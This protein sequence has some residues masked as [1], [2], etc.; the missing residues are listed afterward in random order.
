MKQ[1]LLSQLSVF[2]FLAC[3]TGCVGSSGA[4]SSDSMVNA[5]AVNASSNYTIKQSFVP[6]VSA[7]RGG[8]GYAPEDTME[9]YRN[10]ARIGVDD[11]ET[12]ATITKDG[13]LV[14][15][16]DATLDRT[17]NCTG[18]VADKTYAEILKCDAGYYFTYNQ[19]TTSK[20]DNGP[21]PFR[22]KG[23]VVPL[24][25]E[26]FAYAKSLGAFG[27]TV[28]IEIKNQPGDAGYEPAC[29][30]VA[31]KLIELIQKSGIK[32]KIIVQSFDTSCL[33]TVQQLDATIQTLNLGLGAAVPNFATTRALG[34]TYASPSFN[35]PDFNAQTIAAAKT[36]GIKVNPYTVDKQAD[37][38]LVAGYGVD[39]MI[40][41][42]PACLMQLQKRSIPSRLIGESSGLTAVDVKVCP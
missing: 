26:L 12:D 19:G 5:S 3:L 6:F 22:G 23:V 29:P 15:I 10:A 2:G 27:P 33:L 42:Y 13:Q 1:P 39:G 4:G 18:N 17:T 16:H 25:T 20:T 14:L 41:N 9:A 8:A 37:M 31:G 38:Q 21:F 30:T 35:S 36:S 7:H 34:F 11:L 24:A 32:E 40:T 28:T